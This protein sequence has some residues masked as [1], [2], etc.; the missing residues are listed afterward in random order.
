ME[1]SNLRVASEVT[2]RSLERDVPADPALLCVAVAELG[3]VVKQQVRDA[4]SRGCFEG[5]YHTFTAALS[6]YNVDVMRISEGI[7]QETPAA[8]LEVFQ[9]KA[10]EAA[11]VWAAALEPVLH[12]PGVSPL[13]A[14]PTPPGP[15]N[16]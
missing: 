5:S 2:L 9:S 11:L 12:P 4:E 14:S 13:T 7:P 10:R 6:H 3:D 1:H 8:D 16:E 15:S